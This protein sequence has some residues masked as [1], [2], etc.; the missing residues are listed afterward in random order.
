MLE[1]EC[2]RGTLFPEEEWLELTWVERHAGGIGEWEVDPKKHKA[3]A[4]DF[5]PEH[6]WGASATANAR[7]MEILGDVFQGHPVARVIQG[8]A[9]RPCGCNAWVVYVK[10]DIVL[11]I[12]GL[13]LDQDVALEEWKRW[14]AFH[15]NHARVH[16]KQHNLTAVMRMVTIPELPQ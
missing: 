1:V 2:G 15:A 6:P 16:F 13:F 10:S 8:Y 3:W 14:T 7:Q 5:D 9:Q 12:R 11:C 4:H